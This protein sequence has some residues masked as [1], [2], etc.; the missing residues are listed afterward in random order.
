MAETLFGEEFSDVAAQVAA[1]VAAEALSNAEPE[2]PVEAPATAPSPAAAPAPAAALT[3]APVAAV[4]A[5]PQPAA[6][7][8]GANVENSAV[9]RMET[10]R[11]LNRNPDPI[12]PKKPVVSAN[13]KIR[14]AAPPPSTQP[15]SIEDQI[16]T[17]ITQTLQAI[18][19]R[20]DPIANDDDDDDDDRKGGFFSRFRR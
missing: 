9:R 7:G 16:N 10:V 8:L 3:P 2:T 1:M 20:H 19:T 18:N 17:S 12:P 15:G 4:K 6:N 13:E 11:A 5:N 14:P